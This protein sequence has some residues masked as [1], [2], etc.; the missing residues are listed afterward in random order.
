VAGE[1]KGV[2]GVQI[3]LALNALLASTAALGFLSGL[4]PRVSESPF[5][6]RHA[7]TRELAGVLVML[8]TA[9]WLRSDSRLI[10]FPIIFVGLNFLHSLTELALS[11]NPLDLP[12]AIVEGTFVAL[13]IRF[14]LRNRGG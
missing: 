14:A 3:A 7:G 2:R 12:P 13:Y 10:A 1:P 5:L 11:R 4:M 8:L 9:R 6:G